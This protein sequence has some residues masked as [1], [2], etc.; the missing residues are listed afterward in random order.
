MRL[1]DGGARTASIEPPRRRTELLDLGCCARL[2]RTNERDLASAVDAAAPEDEERYAH[3]VPSPRSTA[4][5]TAWTCAGF[6][7]PFMARMTSPTMRPANSSCA[8]SDQPDA[9]PA[10]QPRSATEA[11]TARS[12]A[13]SS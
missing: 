9:S 4:S 3:G 6:A 8:R 1:E 7:R 10:A 13:S 11:S 2:E 12:T 5:A